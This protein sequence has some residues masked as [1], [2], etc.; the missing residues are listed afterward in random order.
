[1]HQALV[2]K[3]LR[4]SAE[5]IAVAVLGAV[6]ILA[7]MTGVRLLPFQNGESTS[8]PFVSD[9][10][11]SFYFVLLAGGLAI[12]LGLKQSAWE[13]WQGSYFFLLHRPASRRTLFGV[14]LMVGVTVLLAITGALIQL[15][16]MWAATPGTHATPFFWS[17]TIP[18]WQMWFAFPLLY[19]GAFL[20]GVRPGRWFGSRLAPLAA[21]VL[22]VTLCTTV[23]WWWLGLMIAG[24]SVV[25]FV[26]TIFLY[27]ET[28]DY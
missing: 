14:K 26:A 12:L 4:E 15:Y 3:E 13:L 2:W 19:L 11:F 9:S 17:M 23:P 7:D 18:M 25:A 16:A 1:M 5:L 28:R 24:I 21:S 27:V 20:S 22:L 6:F 10:N 8:Y